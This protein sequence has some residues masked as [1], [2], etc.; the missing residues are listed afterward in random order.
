MSLVT[1]ASADYQ[2]SPDASGDR[3]AMCTMFIEGPSA[4]FGRCSKVEG[5]IASRGWCRYF[6]LVT[7]TSPKE[8]PE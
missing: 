3:C 6:E 2:G 8:Q 4:D 1:K 5:T 7:L